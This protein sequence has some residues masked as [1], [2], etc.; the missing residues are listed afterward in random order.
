VEDWSDDGTGSVADLQACIERFSEMLLV[1]LRGIDRIEFA[2]KRALKSFIRTALAPEA[3]AALF[4]VIDA[5]GE[6]PTFQSVPRFTWP[7]WLEQV[8][9]R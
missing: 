7:A 1:C 9:S 4:P 3:A 8:V 2:E 5:I 6:T